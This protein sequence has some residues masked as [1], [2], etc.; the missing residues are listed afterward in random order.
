MK[1]GCFI[2]GIIILTI[3]VASVTYIIQNKFNDFIFKPSRKFIAPM[4]VKNFDENLKIIKNGPE[5]DSLKSLV[6]MYIEEA[7]NI[8]D[9]SGDSLKSFFGFI[10]YVT[11]D[12]VVTS[13]ELEKVKDFIS[14]RRKN[15]GSEKN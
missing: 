1:K 3:V 11:A 10:N 5:K 6:N 9:L 4:F 15:E 8:K 14:S 2:K 12:S 13:K 7:N